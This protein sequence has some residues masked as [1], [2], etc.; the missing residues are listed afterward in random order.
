M[1]LIH[2][3]PG[4]LI[5]SRRNPIGREIKTGGIDALVVPVLLGRCHA[6]PRRLE[7]CVNNLV[8]SN[9]RGLPDS[10]KTQQI[11][12]ALI[13]SLPR[14]VYDFSGRCFN[15]KNSNE[16]V[17]SYRFYSGVPHR[18]TVV[19]QDIVTPITD[20]DYIAGHHACDRYAF[21]MGI[22]PGSKMT[23]AVRE[24]R[25]HRFCEVGVPPGTNESVQLYLLAEVNQLKAASHV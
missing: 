15:V 12:N 13:S 18:V 16:D 9:S 2:E 19:H 3:E 1:A 25:L 8:Y 23:Q 6:D 11:K 10:K 17:L 24:G 5:Y 14:V 21:F 20:E 4:F 22:G 7:D